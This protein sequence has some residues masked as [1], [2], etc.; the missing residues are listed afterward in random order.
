M[1]CS[2]KDPSQEDP[3]V[4]QAYKIFSSIRDVSLKEYITNIRTA[5]K[6]RV[7]HGSRD[8][9]FSMNVKIKPNIT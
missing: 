9:L 8:L 2:K 7:T 3:T 1:R 6:L 5:G 4:R